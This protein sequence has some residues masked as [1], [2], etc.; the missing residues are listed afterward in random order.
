MADDAR[1]STALPRHPKTIK[2]AR[3]LG[4]EGCWSLVCLFLWVADNR[5]D[6]DLQKM[7]S[8]D[9]EIAA[10]WNGEPGSFVSV[11]AAVRFLDGGAGDYK[12]HDWA[13]H[14]PWA[15]GRPGRIAAAKLAANSRWERKRV[16]GDAHSMQS[17]CES[18]ESALP[19]SPPPTSP[20]LTTKVKSVGAFAPP[21]LAQVSEYCFE[22]RNQ[23][24]PQQWFD[25]Y[26][27]NGWM[28]G[29]SRMKDWRA[30]VRTWERNQIN[31]GNGNGKPSD[32]HFV[33]QVPASTP[34]PLKFCDGSGLYVEQSTRRWMNCECQKVKEIPA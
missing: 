31:Q 1:I 28:I 13:Q 21:T 34:C 15:A 24:D 30:A 4:T 18:H 6:G 25:H 12:I 8:E 33:G 14:N 22:R 32:S 7:T 11:L 19:T 16:E 2:L 27:A 17:A 9:I 3:R 5:P 26:C 23:I 20:P 10:G 29:K